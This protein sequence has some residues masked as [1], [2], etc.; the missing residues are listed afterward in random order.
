[1]RWISLVVLVATTGTA[2]ADDDVSGDDDRTGPI[3]VQG[4]L[5]GAT[6][7]LT[8]RIPVDV[9][10]FGRTETAID[11]PPSAVV[12]SAKVTVDGATHQLALLPA[13]DVGAAFDEVRA[14]QAGPARAWALQIRGDATKGSVSAEMLAPRDA[15]LELELRLDAATCYYNDARYVAIPPNWAPALDRALSART[16]PP[17]DELV[18]A[19]NASAEQAW[20]GFP[21]N[22]LAKRPGGFE[23]IGS[24]G[25]RLPLPKQDVAHVELDLAGELA[26]VPRDL[27]TAIVIDASRSVSADEA[28]AQRA[29]VE[30]YLD[31]APHGAVQVIAFAHGAHALLPAWSPAAHTAT[32]IDRALRGLVRRNGSDVDAGLAEAG[33]WLGRVTGTRRVIVFTDEL[34]A[35]RLQE[36]DGAG[37]AKLLPPGTLAHVVALSGVEGAIERDDNAMFGA[38]AA[39]TFGMAVRGELDEHGEV[40]ATLLARPVSLDHVEIAAP[41]WVD[42]GLAPTQCAGQTSLHEGSRCEW[43][44]QGK[45]SAGSVTVTGMM[46]GRKLVRHVAPDPARAL[47]LA[48]SLSTMSEVEGD[49]AREVAHA[50]RAVNS[51]W[52]MFASWG[53]GNGYN[54]LPFVSMCGGGSFGTSGS[55]SSG[56]GMSS[57][58][59]PRLDLKAQFAAA[60]ASCK[61]GDAKIELGVE[62]TL[63]EI[64]DV[65]VSVG[66]RDRERIHECVVAAAWD[67][68]LSIPD[69]PTHAYTQLVF[70]A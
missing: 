64:V 66:G 51:E 4:R 36:G 54:D 28:E 20:I 50:A 56:S 39:A 65:S 33:E 15:R 46:W 34:V 68:M 44:G 30:S 23:R 6:A 10:E 53:G 1:V 38:L 24:V 62:T 49:L 22:G 27:Y 3:V 41:G 19:C 60:V 12:T 8:A 29:I 17:A 21:A 16:L 52:S 42:L 31:A 59:G 69:A 63:E 25:E 2:R 35:G 70:G 18:A 9:L 32:R 47:A 11:L 7:H 26:E 48:R 43:Y 61:P 58:R 57:A 14:R 45:A 37:L 67:T 55:G 5:D 40:D 13:S